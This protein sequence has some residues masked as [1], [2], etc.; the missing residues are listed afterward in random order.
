[1]ESV[2][3]PSF[4]GPY[5]HKF[6]PENRD[7]FHVVRMNEGFLCFTNIFPTCSTSKSI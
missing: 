5:F 3:I 4:S 1:M 2:R 6:G 7:T